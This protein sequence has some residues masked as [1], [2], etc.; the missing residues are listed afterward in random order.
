MKRKFR[1]L[2]YV[3]HDNLSPIKRFLSDI[4]QRTREAKTTRLLNPKA[5]TSHPDLPL[6]P[7]LGR[8]AA[9]KRARGAKAKIFGESTPKRKALAP[10]PAEEAV[11]RMTKAFIARKASLA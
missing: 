4:L 9:K 5:V 10:F 1:S 7:A 2:P 3:L 11:P 8:A 6:P